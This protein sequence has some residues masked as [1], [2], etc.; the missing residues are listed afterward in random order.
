[1]FSFITIAVAIIT[2]S[3]YFIAC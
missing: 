1:M 2:S 3:C